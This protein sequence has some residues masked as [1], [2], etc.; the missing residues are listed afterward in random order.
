MRLNQFIKLKFDIEIF[1]WRICMQIE[2]NTAV[3]GLMERNRD[4]KMMTGSALVSWILM[5][6]I[7]RVQYIS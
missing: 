3:L 7:H 1:I 4:E 5:F 2:R 6:K